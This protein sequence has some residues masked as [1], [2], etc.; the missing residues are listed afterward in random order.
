MYFSRT[1]LP[2]TGWKR[3]KSIHQS[4]L[5]TIKTFFVDH[6]HNAHNINVHEAAKNGI[7]DRP[8]AGVTPVCSPRALRTSIGGDI[9]NIGANGLSRF[10]FFPCA[11]FDKPDALAASTSVHVKRS[12]F[13]SAKDTDRIV[14]FGV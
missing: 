14:E 10:P 8:S 3:W 1:S 6:N 12:T 4:R 11:Y 7:G 5:D 2:H 9:A 13:L